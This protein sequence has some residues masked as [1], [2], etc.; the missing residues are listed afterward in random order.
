MIG[1]Y[2]AA[3]MR[4]SGIFLIVGL[5]TGS[6]VF[7]GTQ[8]VKLSC[9][10]DVIVHHPFGAPDKSRETVTVE[11]LSDPDTRFRAILIDSLTIGV[12]V[13]NAKGD[14]VTSF[15]DNSTEDRWEIWNDRVQG[16]TKWEQMASIDRNTGQ[17]IAREITTVGGV[18]EHTEASGT[19]NKLDGSKRK[20]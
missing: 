5:A 6:S 19:C 1:H 14:S 7:A 13:G 4:L 9:V 17:L 8:T 20:F 12:S 11:M 18:S 16:G 15:K 3:S 10:L 2:S